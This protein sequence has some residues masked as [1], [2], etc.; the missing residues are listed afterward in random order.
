[1][2]LFLECSQE[3]SQCSDWLW[4]PSSDILEESV[5][6][7]F[8]IMEATGCCEIFVHKYDTSHSVCS[9]CLEDIRCVHYT[10]LFTALMYINHMTEDYI[11]SRKGR[12]KPL[13]G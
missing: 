11:A 6:S 3:R 5:S 10:G 4:N 12:F 1:M 8:L 13:E 9:Y 7:Y 2:L